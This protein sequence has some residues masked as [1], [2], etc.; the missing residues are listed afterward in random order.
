ME[1]IPPETD[2]MDIWIQLKP[3][4]AC[5]TPGPGTVSAVQQEEFIYLAGAL[6]LKSGLYS[7][8]KRDT[9]GW[10]RKQTW[11]LLKYLL[12]VLRPKLPEVLKGGSPP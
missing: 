9:E 1:K 6:T 2:K 3:L 8:L 7:N 4:S 12:S 10:G 11:G 5:Q